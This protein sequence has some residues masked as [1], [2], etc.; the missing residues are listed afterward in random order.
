MMIKT[1]RDLS[2]VNGKNYKD[3][4]NPTRILKI[5]ELN[6]F[7]RVVAHSDD[8]IGFARV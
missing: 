4:F 7:T 6:M 2:A 8:P 3:E 1:C 5:C